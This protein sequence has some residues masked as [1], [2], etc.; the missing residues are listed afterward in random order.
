MYGMTF[1]LLTTREGKKMGKT[2]KG[3]VWLDPEKTSPYEFFQYWRNIDDAE[4]QNCLRLLTDVDLDYIDSIDTTSG[5]AINAAKEKLAYELTSLVHSKEEADKALNTAR[6]LFSGAADTEHMPSTTLEESQLTD[7]KIGL[8]SL[9]VA[10]GL[11]SSN[12]EARR[13]VLPGSVSVNGEKVTDPTFAVTAEMLKK[14]IVL[15][16]GKKV[17]HKATL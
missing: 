1:T 11:A 9:L 13:L 2:E 14:G 6:A 17:Y 4:V 16:K 3:A 12:G 7:G 5:S 15:K 10:T 8:L